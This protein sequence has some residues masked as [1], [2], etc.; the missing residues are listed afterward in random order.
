ME[1]LVKFTLRLRDL[2]E[3]LVDRYSE[4]KESADS[5]PGK[6]AFNLRSARFSRVSSQ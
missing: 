2:Q 1:E 6:P 3:F 5:W 4:R